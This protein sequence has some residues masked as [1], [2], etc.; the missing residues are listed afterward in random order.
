M[1]QKDSEVKINP[2]LLILLV[3]GSF[4]VG[5]VWAKARY[6]GQEGESVKITN[7]DQN[8]SPSPAQNQNNFQAKKTSKP[9]VKFFVMSFCPFGNQA[10]QGLEPVYQ[11][12]KDKVAWLPR[13]I[14]D[15]WQTWL[16]QCEQS[17]PRRVASEESKNQCQQ[18]IDSGQ[19]QGMT[20][21]ACLKTYFPYKTA[22]ECQSKECLGGKAGDFVS[23]HDQPAKGLFHEANQDVREICALQQNNLDSWWKFVLEVNKNCDSSN[24]DTCWKQPAKTAGLNLEAIS[25][26]EKNQKQSL[27]EKEIAEAK[28]YHASGSPTVYINEVLYNGGRAPEDYKKAI[29]AS[30]ENSP[31]ECQ[32]ILGEESAPA[33]GGC[34]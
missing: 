33:T 24:A 10:E 23:L 1:T 26:C 18:A 12:L 17:C 30:F 32:K 25:L 15:N 7:K 8:T 29:C 4:L 2:L 16:S 5:S 13:Y 20:V 3:L 28:K 22:E 21:D 19:L 34:N 11:L 14:L 27:L 6:L 31:E 9:E